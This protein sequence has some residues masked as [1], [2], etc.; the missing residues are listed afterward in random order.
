[1]GRILAAREWF[2]PA[3]KTSG[4]I[5]KG[6]LTPE[7]FLAAG[8]ELTF[9]CP[10]WAWESGTV[11]RS[12]LPPDKQFLITRHVPCTVRA[13]ELENQIVTASTNCM[14]ERDSDDWL[15]PE[16]VTAVERSSLEDD[17]DILDDEGEVMKLTSSQGPLSAEEDDSAGKVDGEYSDITS[18]E[19]NGVLEDSAVVAPDIYGE[20]SHIVKVRTYDLSITYDKYYQTPRLW[21]MGYDGHGQPLTEEEMMQD[22]MQDYANK[23]VTMETHPHISKALQ[24]SIHPCRHAQVMKTIVS[25]LI[26]QQED[27]QLPPS[28][29]TY[30]FVFLKFVSSIIPT[31]NYDF[32]VD[33]TAAT[34]AT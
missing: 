33:V 14:N 25:N 22:V 17:F 29:E 18:F 9:R 27:S 12:H 8:D 24:A 26:S 13:S 34:K 21:M 11:Q 3:L 31:I 19:D 10:T 32:T 28:V 4:Y 30:L 2:T 23:T 15:L 5:A 6:V 16:V 7:E 1:M 20:E